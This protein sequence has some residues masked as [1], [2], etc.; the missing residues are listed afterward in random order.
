MIE[1]FIAHSAQNGH[2]AQTYEAHI[3]GV[4]KKALGYAMEA[5]QYS[6]KVAGILTSVVEDSA[7]L[8][9]LGKLD[10][11]N[12]KVLQNP[13]SGQRH[14]P[15]NHTDAG[16]AA[17]ISTGKAHAAMLVYSHHRGLPDVSSER[18]CKE[19][20]LRDDHPSIRD[21]V[22]RT[23][24]ELLSCHHTLFPPLS[25]EKPRNYDSDYNVLLRIA[26]SCLADADHTDTAIAY[27]Q[28]S[29]REELPLLRADE[30]LA[31]LDR[32]VSGLSGGD[33]RDR[34]RS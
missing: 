12:Q 6:K 28:A 20:I 5:E 10:D 1:T 11:E 25:D 24:S 29:E 17:L 2:P 18:L 19:V 7:A 4:H 14:L 26:L 23:L 27:G 8:H 34:L 15:I 32:Y 21:H 13:K 9:D 3:Q 22:N 30:R 16:S 33:E 31:A